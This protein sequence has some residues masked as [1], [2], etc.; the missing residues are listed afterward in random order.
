MIILTAFTIGLLAAGLR[1][2]LCYVLAGCLIVVAFAL[3]ALFSAGAVSLIALILALLA[4]NAGIAAP[5]VAAFILARR[6]QA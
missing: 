1:S 4:Y 2:V 3:A 6:R 5:V